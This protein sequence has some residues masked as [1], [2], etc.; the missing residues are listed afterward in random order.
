MSVWFITGTSSGFG[1]AIA[2]A[3][4]LAGEEVAATAR[5]TEALAD[6]TREFPDAVRVYALDVTNTAQVNTVVAQTVQDFGR[7]DVVVSNAGYG[8]MAA[9]EEAS[10]AQI[11]RC[12]QTNFLGSLSVM[13][14]ALPHL[15]AQKSGHIV[16]ISAIAALA[17]HAGF[18]VYGG[19]KAAI[20]A[21]CDALKIEVAPLGIKVTV[22]S[23]GPYRTDFIGR[24]QEKAAT[25]IDDYDAT[26]GKFAAYLDRIDGRQPG[27]PARAAE[28]IVQMVADG[29]SP[30]RLFLGKYA[31]DA[32]RK[33]AS[34][35]I[36]DATE[37]EE[38]SLATD[39]P[40]P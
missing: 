7:L 5:N 8:L 12:V 33:S 1:K 16:Q 31:L 38:A 22:V 9:L 21:A 34:Q 37:W 25:H 28:L 17:N 2:R 40:R 18:S 32:A 20:E 35:F 4:L 39:F 23:P 30:A 29:K 11:E 13:R 27:D 26:S 10:D 19:A 24:S 14:A 3:A 6:L 15:R 36:K